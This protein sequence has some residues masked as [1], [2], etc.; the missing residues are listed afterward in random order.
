MDIVNKYDL[1]DLVRRNASYREWAHEP[2]EIE[3][4]TI[5][6]GAEWKRKHSNTS[7]DMLNKTH[8]E[9]EYHRGTRARLKRRFYKTIL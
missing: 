5:E 9:K 3:M 4:V 8:T 1:D 7:I 6:D 2:S